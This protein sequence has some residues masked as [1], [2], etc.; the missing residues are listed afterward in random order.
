MSRLN[1]LPNDILYTIFDFVDPSISKRIRKSY[2]EGNVAEAQKY[3]VLK[4]A[5][6]ILQLFG[7]AATWVD[8]FGKQSSKAV[9][10]QAKAAA[11]A[12]KFDQEKAKNAKAAAEALSDFKNGTISAAEAMKITAQEL[13]A[14]KIVDEVITEPLGGAH[15]D[16]VGTVRAVSDAVEQNLVALSSL[17]PAELRKQRKERFY[18]IGRA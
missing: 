1:T 8:I 11:M 6:G 3:A 4:E 7:G 13:L 5:P 14:N 2:A 9:A 18:A 12:S 17:S 10:A 15:R 16:A